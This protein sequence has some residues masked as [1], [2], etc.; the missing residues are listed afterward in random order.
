MYTSGGMLRGKNVVGKSLTE[1]AQ[2]KA[3]KPVMALPSTSVCTSW[4]PS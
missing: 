3:S 1:L 2:L 4:V